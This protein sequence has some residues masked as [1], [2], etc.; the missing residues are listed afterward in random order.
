MAYTI[1]IT[2]VLKSLFDV[3]LARM[4]QIPES[5]AGITWSELEEAFKAYEDSGSRRRIHLR[6]SLIFQQDQQISDTDS[7]RRIFRELVEAVEVPA[8]VPAPGPSNPAPVPTPNSAPVP[9]P[10]SNPAPVHT[11]NRTPVD[12]PRPAQGA[13]SEPES[14]PRRRRGFLC[15]C[16]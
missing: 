16:G 14:E 5:S 11:S 13:T 3:K 8:P 12:K 9:T 15:F 10:K 2:T 4:P 7:F 6:I 1:D